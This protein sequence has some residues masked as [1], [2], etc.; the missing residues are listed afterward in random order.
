V[1]AHGV[2]ADTHAIIWYVDAPP[3]LSPDAATALDAAADDD[4]Q[5]IYLS[6][7]TL[8]E[9]QYLTEKSKIK[10]TVLVQVLAE[11]DAPQPIIEVIPLDR[12]VADHLALIPR[13][14]VPDMP[15]RIIAATA[16]TLNLPLVTADTKIRALTNVVTVW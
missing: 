13:A 5:R 9:M 11:I 7:I 16:L 12:E 1:S 6:A 3:E 4:T 14:I 15:D 8:V 2:V 10:P